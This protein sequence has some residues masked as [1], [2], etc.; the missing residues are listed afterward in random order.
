MFS[1]QT[2]EGY[3]YRE[4]VT[5]TLKHVHA[6]LK[7]DGTDEKKEIAEAIASILS[8]KEGKAQRSAAECVC[9]GR[10][11]LGADDASYLQSGLAM[12]WTTAAGKGEDEELTNAELALAP[13]GLYDAPDS[14]AGI[15]AGLLR[16]MQ[17]ENARLHEDAPKD[18]R[19]I[20]D[21]IEQL[22][23]MPPIGE[24]LGDTKEEFKSALGIIRS[25]ASPD[26]KVKNALVDGIRTIL[27]LAQGPENERT[28]A[29]IIGGASDANCAKQRQEFEQSLQELRN[30]VEQRKMAFEQ[31]RTSCAKSSLEAT[32]QLA[33]V[34]RE[35]EQVQAKAKEQLVEAKSATDEARK[36]LESA[37]NELQRKEAM[38]NSAQA[39]LQSQLASSRAE[40]MQGR[41]DIEL[42]TRELQAKEQDV[43][44]SIDEFADLQSKLDQSTSEAAATNETLRKL[45]EKQEKMTATIKAQLEEAE[46]LRKELEEAASKERSL[47][48]ENAKQLQAAANVFNEQTAKLEEALEQVDK[49]GGGYLSGFVEKNGMKGVVENLRSLLPNPASMSALSDDEKKRA[50]DDAANR[51]IAQLN[52]PFTYNDFALGGKLVA[53]GTELETA[54]E[55]LKVAVEKLE[56][57]NSELIELVTTMAQKEAKEKAN[58]DKA[59]NSDQLARARLA[60]ESE[61]KRRAERRGLLAEYDRIKN[62]D[63]PGDKERASEILKMFRGESGPAVADSSTPKTESGFRL[64]AHMRG[65]VGQRGPL[66]SAANPMAPLDAKLPYALPSTSAMLKVLPRV[67]A[68]LARVETPEETRAIDAMLAQPTRAGYDENDVEAAIAALRGDYAVM[69][70]NPAQE[71]D[72]RGG[73]ERA[74]GVR[75]LPEGEHG[76]TLAEVAALEHLVARCTAVAAEP[77]TPDGEKKALRAMAAS[78]KLRQLEPLYAVREAAAYDPE[79]V[80]CTRYSQ[81]PL[82]PLVT[83][84]CAVVRGKLSY[85]LNGALRTANVPASM[86]AP[87]RERASEDH[88]ARKALAKTSLETAALRNRLRRERVMDGPTS[89][90]IAP[91][92]D[93]VT[94][95]SAPTGMAGADE[96]DLV[97]QF[98]AE[99]LGPEAY[100][101]AMTRH[102]LRRALLSAR[103]L[104]KENSKEKLDHLIA[105]TEE[106]RSAHTS[107]Q[108]RREALWSQ[109]QRHVAISHDRLW[110]FVRTLSGC[111][112]GDVNEVITMAEE[113]AVK[114]TKALQEQ[115]LAVAKRVSDAQA[116]IVETIVSGMARESKLLIEKR[117][118]GKEDDKPQ[119]VVIDGQARKELRDLAS[120]ESGRPFFEANVAMRSQMTQHAAESQ[121]TLAELLASVSGVG[122]QIQRS[123][124]DTLMTGSGSTGS[125]PSLV[126][127]SH[128]SNS[129]FVS[130]RADSVAAIRVTHERMN[131][132]LGSRGARRLNLWECIEG[133]CVPLCTRFAEMAGHVLVQARSSTG[134]SAMYVSHVAVQT[135][136][137]QARVALERLVTVAT[138]YARRVSPPKFSSRERDPDPRSVA[139]NAGAGVKDID[140]GKSITGRGL[141][142]P[143]W[144]RLPA[145]VSS[146][147]WW[148]V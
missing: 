111:L 148:V 3:Q 123:L 68:L 83:T 97:E 46:R 6:G 24:A 9:A 119:L 63:K 57:K 127:L 40:V 58:R 130:L 140:I 11:A 18:L 147:G 64:Y 47:R 20:V 54:S 42:V 21:F 138:I 108:D 65:L 109:F 2:T 131:V 85:P 67:R 25:N 59:R 23:D 79:S 29:N 80:A 50:A 43:A 88:A 128:P 77:S 87:P 129:Y 1:L 53:T 99:G 52:S 19:S 14:V 22:L 102:L 44:A 71:D 89:V 144:P 72:A 35:L 118:G 4:F 27:E 75:W 133:G 78:F 90:Y 34:Q 56:Q 5:Q 95:V 84:P 112:G 39:E 116:K 60:K 104:G 121:T 16:A 135:N 96:L 124:E 146:S 126:E 73:V 93:S 70:E 31:L 7:T 137:V 76:E 51:A 141:K 145:E 26:E 49:K 125:G 10:F 12:L 100:S 115:R 82:R 105:K 33:S 114:A 134:V 98:V 143:M 17:A 36:A 142:R 101:V 91:S 117:K 107:A 113:S 94:M 92:L 69:G 106:R 41:K 45:R 139:M 61:R 110:V 66:D 86:L 28:I 15:R 38:A 132:E 74:Y 30:E 81:D 62:S 8:N 103:A 120:G 55:E 136:A 13:S 32:R 48:E 122:R 37:T